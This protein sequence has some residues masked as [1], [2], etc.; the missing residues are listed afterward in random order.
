MTGIKKTISA[1][2]AV[3]AVLVCAMFVVL[4]QRAAAVSAVWDGTIAASFAGG[5]GTEADPYQISSGAELAYFAQA[6]NDGTLATADTYFKLTADIDLGD[7]EWTPIGQYSSG[8]YFDGMFDG[9][10]HL[11]TNLYISTSQSGNGLFGRTEYSYA[12]CQINNVHVSGSVSGT[13]NVGGVC[14]YMWGSMSNCS[15]TGT[16]SGTGQYVGGVAGSMRGIMNGCYSVATV[17]TSSSICGGVCGAIDNNTGTLYNC[18]SVGNVSSYYTAG[19]VSGSNSKV[20]EN[21]FSIG[22]VTA[23][24]NVGGVIGSNSSDD[25][26][27][28]CYYSTDR[29]DGNGVG[30]NGNYNSGSV[31]VY[32]KTTR[33]IAMLSTELGEGWTKGSISEDGRVLTL[34]CYTGNPAVKLYNF[35]VNGEDNWLPY[36]LITTADELAAIADDLSGNYVLANDITLPAPAEGESS[37]WTPIGTATAPFTGNFSGDGYAVKNLILGD[38][39]ASYTGLFGASSGTIMNVGIESGRIVGKEFVGAIVGSSSGTVYGCYNNADVTSEGSRATGG[40][41]G[42]DSAGTI[43]A[44]YNTGDITGFNIVGGICGYMSGT[45]VSDCYNTGDILVN[46]SRGGGIAGFNGG[47][48]AIADCFSTGM[49]N[50][51]A[52]Y[53]IRG[54]GNCTT[55]NCYYLDGSCNNAG[56]GVSA[57]FEEICALDLDSTDTLWTA[58]EAGSP[59]TEGRLRTTESILPSI[60]GVGEAV[61]IVTYEYN[62]SVTDTA[63]W[64]DCYL[65][66]SAEELLLIA[67]DSTK[68]D[69][70]IVLAADIDLTG[71]TFTPIGNTTTRFTGKFSGDGHTISGLNIESVNAYQGIF[72]CNNGL[73][74]LLNVSG[75]VTGGADVGGIVGMNYTGGVIYGC[76]SDVEVTATGSH[77]GGV[78]GASDGSISVCANL[79]DVSGTGN[80]GGIGGSAN[81]TINDCFNTGDISTS[82]SRA[83]GICGY[84]AGD[85]ISGCYSTGRISGTSL[86]GGICGA[87]DAFTAVTDCYY[88]NNGKQELD[89]TNGTELTLT[90]LC[91]NLPTG[92]DSAVWTKGSYIITDI[93]GRNATMECTLPTLT[94]V[95]EAQELSVDVY[96]FSLSSTSDWQLYTPIYDAEDLDAI[97]NDLG[98]NY[99]LMNDI[100]MGAVEFTPIGTADDAFTGKFS[101]DGYALSGLNI[102]MPDTSDVGL[103]GYSTGLIMNVGIESGSVSGK[104]SVGGICGT[105][106]GGTITGCYNKADVSGT[107]SCIG[108]ICGS[109]LNY[110]SI[111]KVYNTGSVSGTI[112]VG[113]ICGY[114][115]GCS[116]GNCWNSGTVSGTEQ[117]GGICGDQYGGSL[118]S[119]YN[120]GKVTAD[121]DYGGICGYNSN[122]GTVDGYYLEGTSTVGCAGSIAG[123]ITDSVSITELCALDLGSAWTAGSSIA[124]TADGRHRTDSYALP[125]VTALGEDSIMSGTVNMY[126]F[127]IDDAHDWQVYTAITDADELQAMADDLAGNYVLMNDIDMGDA[128]FTPVGTKDAPFDGRFSGDGHSLNDLTIDL[129]DT[130]YVGLFGYNTGLIMNVAVA[131]GEISGTSSVSAICGVNAGNG[132]IINCFNSAAVNGK[133]GNIGGICGISQNAYIRNCYNSGTI[134][135]NSSVGGVCGNNYTG[136]KLYNCYNIGIVTGETDYVGGVCGRNDAVI[137]NCYYDNSASTES[138]VDGVTAL[139]ALD[140]T[141]SNA[142]ETMALDTDVW[143]CKSSDKTNGKAYYPYLRAFGESSAPVISYTAKLTFAYD[144]EQGNPVY[145]DSLYFDIGALV[146]FGEDGEFAPVSDSYADGKGSFVVKLNGEAI[147]ESFDIYDGSVVQLE[148]KKGDICA[149]EN[150]FTLVYNADGSDYFA[151]SEFAVCD[152]EIGRAPVA[153][154]AVE[155]AQPQIEAALDTEPVV[156]VNGAA[157]S[158]F[159]WY[160]ASGDEVSGNADYSGKY[161]AVI[162]LTADDNHIFAEDFAVS[163]ASGDV[164]AELSDDLLTA[165]VSISFAKLPDRVKPLVTATAG[166][167][168]VKLTWTPIVGATNYRVFSYLNGKYAILG[169]TTSASYIATGLKGGVEY[170]FLVRAF[171]YGYWTDFTVDDNVYATPTAAAVTKPVLTATAGV[172]Q[173]KLSWTAVDGA[174]SYRVFSY[175]GGKYTQLALTTDTTFTATGLVGGTEYGFLVRAL[176]SDIWTPFTSADLVYATPSAASAKPVVSAKAGAEQVKLTWNAVSGATAYRVFSYLDGR[177]TQLTITAATS[178]IAAGLDAGVEY[179]FL[180][181]AQVNG[182]WTAF[183]SADLVYASPLAAGSDKPVVTAVAGVRKV[184]LTWNAVSGATDYRVF[185]YLG[186]KY[187]QLT[188]TDD[189]EYTAENLAAGTEY[190]FL[191]RALVNGVWTAFSTDDLTYATPTAPVKPVV[192]AVAGTEQVKLSWTAVVGAA[193][194]RVFSY[195]SG[196]YTELTITTGTTYTATGLTADTEYGFLVRAYVNNSWTAFSTDDIAYATPLAKAKPVPVITSDNGEVVIRWNSITGATNYRIFSYLNGGY[197]LIGTTSA[198]IYITNE[199]TEGVEYGFLVRAY[200]DGAWTP[201]TTDDNVYAVI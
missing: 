106:Y 194:Y 162:T 53:A 183:S 75:K 144:A 145:G 63:Q 19:G 52:V 16:V 198:T 195:L 95:C 26:I 78:C 13:D 37:N 165:T 61:Q 55:T 163:A 10:G 91:S 54:D 171:V 182:A 97:A 58:G 41:C 123:V 154:A 92:F 151:I 5:T 101:G 43:S 2:T 17:T 174:T 102:D 74:M 27:T 177:Y 184:Y 3:L 105:N 31:T 111:G 68:W 80:T 104:S 51:S 59:V 135:G 173:V 89:N 6:T 125:Y 83:G 197:K 158:G 42:F 11:I 20:C 67:G 49:I 22:N 193:K 84:A 60:S 115:N 119:C 127:G 129:P 146:A 178:Y 34:P 33:E 141:A 189:T 4:P 170:G 47:S 201:Y 131:G 65:V 38:A 187:T 122:N 137:T 64:E 167:G 21:S 148:Y 69:D 121:S 200:V 140:M 46:G 168:Q 156:T 14:G 50:G 112:S 103:F 124:G 90:A 181:R 152:V 88:Y 188:V 130:N 157:V 87:N 36:T 98:G 180:V 155:I 166:Q 99:I 57:T 149:G 82:S 126:D 25:I 176:V 160:D 192:T 109:M 153:T 7:V 15:F 28:N 9:G 161:T 18:F 44:C 70:N 134:S 1:W 185:S 86:T 110:G 23:N 29:Y 40:I 48:G 150:T 117:V 113:G 12:N 169:D 96:D 114:K 108:G 120:L 186:G 164:S 8:N 179:G 35:G 45:S 39:N 24:G 32:G 81:G 107:E 100:D 118:G 175:L 147:T 172:E 199:L 71:K 94:N 56:G 133:Y 142:L 62:Y 139:S 77:A 66:D 191:V 85:S 79:G 128:E 73:V 190:G 196:R 138:A 116:L 93:D 136:G 76:V 132:V 143:G 30:E 159:G 72:G